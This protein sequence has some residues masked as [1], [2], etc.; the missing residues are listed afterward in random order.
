MVAK[1]ANQYRGIVTYLDGYCN[2]RSGK[3]HSKAYMENIASI[4][5]QDGLSER[6]DIKGESSDPGSSWSSNFLTLGSYSSYPISYYDRV[7]IEAVVR[8]T[9]LPEEPEIEEGAPPE[10]EKIRIYDLSYKQ[11]TN[12]GYCLA[13]SKNVE[14]SVTGYKNSSENYYETLKGTTELDLNTSYHIIVT[15]IPA[16]KAEI[17]INNNIEVT[18]DLT[19]YE[20][21]N[22]CNFDSSFALLA[23]VGHEAF[24]TKSGSEF[25]PSAASY[26]GLQVGMIRVYNYILDEEERERGYND[27]KTRFGVM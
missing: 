17:Y 23:S 15:H 14:W 7:S 18:K 27:A 22:S 1:N 12:K 19:E 13:V 8:F 24:S 11:A 2:T 4:V 9:E 21:Y 16:Q 20:G 6:L 10:P 26:K 3:D 5:T 25:T